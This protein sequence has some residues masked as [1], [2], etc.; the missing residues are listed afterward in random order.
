MSFSMFVGRVVLPVFGLVIAS[1]LVIQT[2]RTGRFELPNFA[3]APVHTDRNTAPKG[4]QRDGPR[5]V[6]AEG[7]VVA[8]PGAQ[9]VISSQ[10]PGTI[11]RVLVGEKS[12]VR[13]GDLLLE[14]E[15]DEAAARVAEAAARLAE[16]EAELDRAEFDQRQLEALQPRPPSYK[17][18]VEQGRLNLL[19]HRALRDAAKAARDRLLARLKRHQIVAPI[20]GV[21]TLRSVHPGETVGTDVPL[22]T[23]VDLTRLRVEAEVDEYD[24]AHCGLNDVATITSEAYP[25]RSWQGRVEEISD[26][27]VARKIRPEDPS[28]P[29][30]TRILPVRIALRDTTPLRLGQRVEVEIVA[31]APAIKPAPAPAALPSAIESEAPDKSTPPG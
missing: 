24:A 2:V 30:D 25:G 15:A 19:T 29:T 12:S 23:I 7:R 13:K 6:V 14:F 5:K 1:A 3:P 20:D 28:R 21:I 16:V 31:D 8:Y 18:D 27:M 22:L 17:E 26:T 4:S 11:L 10:I 9:I